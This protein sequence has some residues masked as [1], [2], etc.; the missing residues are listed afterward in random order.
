MFNRIR[1]LSIQIYFKASGKRFSLLR[2]IITVILD[3]ISHIKPTIRA[4]T[5]IFEPGS[6]AV[7]MKDVF[8]LKFHNFLV[9][10]EF[11]QTY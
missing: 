1:S 4:K 9:F 3:L 6:E 11:F 5:A 7:H 8:A 2:L 10:F